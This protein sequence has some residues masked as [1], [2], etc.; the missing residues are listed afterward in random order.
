MLRFRDRTTDAPH[1]GG[2]VQNDFL[3]TLCP[4]DFEHLR[5]FLQP[6]E[7][8]RHAI[9]HEANKPVDAVY[10]VESGIVSRVART[11]A[12]GAVEVA[13]V[14][15]SGLVGLSV[16]LGTNIALHRTVVQIPGSALRI[17]AAD[18]QAIMAKN[19]TIRD[20]LLRY[21]QLLMNQ[22]AQVALCNAKHEIDK[23]VARWLL[24]AH[25][26]VAG[27][28]LPVTHDLLAMMLGVRRAGISEALAELEDKG[29]ISKAR[30][31]LRI[32]S[33][34]ALKAQACECY[35][36]IDDRFSWQ[37]AMTHY[38]HRLQPDS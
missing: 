28:Q 20:H 8:K 31:A 27:N 26:R 3:A 1:R 4:A 10:F 22:K 36:I 7:L 33:R 21:V 6:V 25:D 30:G 2:V 15:R 12:D 14:G 35:K 5:P 37:R 16:I 24:L 13:V 29:V 17:P 34:E 9:I 38:E 23:R 32:V 18:L 11:Q 19:P